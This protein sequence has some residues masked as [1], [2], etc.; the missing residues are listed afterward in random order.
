VQIARAPDNVIEP[1][2]DALSPQIGDKLEDEMAKPESHPLAIPEN[3]INVY[4]GSV[5]K[6]NEQGGFL[7]SLLKFSHAYVHLDKDPREP[8][9]GNGICNINMVLSLYGWPVYFTSYYK[10]AIQDG[11]L[12]ATN[13]GGAIGRLPIHPWLMQHLDAGF[14]NLWEALK[15]EKGL[16]DRAQS[17][18]VSKDPKQPDKWQ[19]VVVTKPGGKPAAAPRPA[20]Q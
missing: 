13:V 6:S 3:A 9:S 12:Q 1:D 15:R 18:S 14:K 4:L 5:V 7:A 20:P 2:K 19:V 8:E 17:V 10:L 11:Q 16:L